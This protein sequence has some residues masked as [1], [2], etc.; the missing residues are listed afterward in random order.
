MLL[1]APWGVKDWLAQGPYSRCRWTNNCAAVRGPCGCTHPSAGGHNHRPR[2]ASA[3]FVADR[4][5]EIGGG[6]HAAWL[7]G[8]MVAASGRANMQPLG[9]AKQ[10]DSRFVGVEFVV[11][12][13]IDIEQV[14]LFPDRPPGS[15]IA[16]CA[17]ICTW[18]EYDPFVAFDGF[19]A[20]QV[21]RRDQRVDGARNAL[22]GSELLE[23]GDCN[24]SDGADDCQCHECFVQAE[25][26]L[27]ARRAGESTN[28]GLLA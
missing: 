24:R 27:A 22:A 14:A 2:R 28:C 25:G 21:Q 6:R 5:G 9:G 19:A 3:E 1:T 8:D 16:A 26:A 4:D 12:V 23:S 20:R 15:A 17:A 13:A 11:G 18:A 7:V 10:P